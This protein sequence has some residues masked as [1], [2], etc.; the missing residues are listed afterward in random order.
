M[1]QVA[2]VPNPSGEVRR[3]MVYDSGDAGVY[4]FHYHSTS[5]GPS[6]ADFWFETVVDAITSAQQEYGIRPHDWIPVADPRPGCQHDW[7]APVQTKCGPDGKPLW[8]QF[9]PLIE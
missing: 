8:G 7:I 1:R 5:D 2:L 6:D 4:L 3:V 9:E